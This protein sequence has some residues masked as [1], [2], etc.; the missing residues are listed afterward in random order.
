MRSLRDWLL[1]GILVFLVA[2]V[3]RLAIQ[4]YGNHKSQ[5]GLKAKEEGR[6]QMSDAVRQL[7]NRT[8]AP[9][10][11]LDGQF[12]C[13]AVSVGE[14]SAHPRLEKCS[15]PAERSGPMDRFETDLR[16]GNFVLRQTDLYL[17][18]VFEVPLTR[19]YNS[20]DYLQ[21]NPI[22]AFGRHAN[23]PF[24]IAPIGNRYP[25]TYQFLVLED[26]DFFYFP[27]VSRG[28][29]FADAV[30]QHTE[31]STGFYKAVET[32]NGDGWTLWR[33]D[34]TRIVFPEAYSA[35]S[36]A[37]GA[38]VEI[39]NSDGDKLQLIR[40]RSRS[41]QEIRTPHGRSIKFE[42]D[43]QSR[44]VRVEDDQ[45]HWAEYAYDSNSMLADAK[46]SSGRA[47]H[48]SYDGDLMIEASDE[49]RKVLVRNSYQNHWLVRQDF[50]NGQVFA[51]SY[52]PPDAHSS[53]AETVEVTL[54][55][56]GKTGVETGDAV[57]E[58]RK[59]PPQ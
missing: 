23:H 4:A 48:Y 35:Q 52:F 40:D 58:A 43:N 22:H 49:D 7:L 44:I 8:D 29:G 3:S 18:D 59:H 28:T 11:R 31:T 15:M 14:S 56:G 36:A 46:F 53:Y 13:V 54:P 45:G 26:G 57:P 55:G 5:I 10:P 34:G 39:R 9:A 32:W 37:Q 33:T 47:R 2:T 25:Y 6:V 17:K 42:Y 38:A 50:G 1:F 16:Y 51:Y 41:L 21:P 30:Y 27:R 20:N 24:D 12:F 19:T